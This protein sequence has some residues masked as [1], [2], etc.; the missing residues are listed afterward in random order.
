MRR[1]GSSDRI[2]DTM[3]MARDKRGIWYVYFS[4]GKARSLRTRDE[5]EARKLYRE[6]R[7]EWLRGKLHL[8]ERGKRIILKDFRTSYLKGREGMSAKTYE[9]DDTALGKLA[10]YLGESTN[11][12]DI[13]QERMDSFV[14]NMLRSIKP[15]SANLYMRHI[16]AALNVAKEW[17]YIKDVPR[18]KRVREDE[19]AIRVVDFADQATLAKAITDPD[20]RRMAEVFLLTGLRRSELATLRWEKVRPP[21]LIVRGKG[22]KER[23]VPMIPRVME[24]LGE[25]GKPTDKVFPRWGAGRVTK[26][27]RQ[28]ANAAGLPGVRL[29]DLRHTS[30]SMLALGGADVNA[31][32]TILGHTDLETTQRYLHA[33]AG[34]LEKAMQAIERVRGA[35]HR[36][37]AAGIPFKNQTAAALSEVRFEDAGDIGTYKENK[38]LREPGEAD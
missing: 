27:F 28:Y 18:I 13:D 16:R 14:A 7:T 12:R 38:G 11:L 22:R 30:A 15:T 24:L 6:V 36:Q 33:F 37:G 26:L 9:A 32:R 35:G 4:R 10:A 19:K 34:Q 23:L 17:G 3:R 8:L 20:F 1:S 2:R 5:S 25:R 21:F 31:I 29:H